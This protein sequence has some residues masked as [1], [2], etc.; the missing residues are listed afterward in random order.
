MWYEND[1]DT[2]IL[3]RNLAFPL[4]RALV[5]V[6]DPLAKRVFKEEIAL[7]LERGYPSVVIHLINQGY[8]K[9]FNKKEL[10]FILENQN[11]INNLSKWFTQFKDMPKGLSE[12]IKANLRNLKCHYCNTKIAQTLIQKHLKGESVRCEY[13]YTSIFK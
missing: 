6:G 10:K 1:Y 2:R 11:F 3:H 7:R 13:C 4:L 8:L 9:Y 5:K 12:K